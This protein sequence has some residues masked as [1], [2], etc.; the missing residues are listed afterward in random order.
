MDSNDSQFILGKNFDR[1]KILDDT[2]ELL[3]DELNLAVP[4]D[5][6]KKITNEV[7]R[8]QRIKSERFE[9]D[10][11]EYYKISDQELRESN[12]PKDHLE[13]YDF[14]KL[15]VPLTLFAN[16]GYAFTEVRCNI[17]F[18]KG[19]E[20]ERYQPIIYDIFPRQAWQTLLNIE[21]DLQIGLDANLKFKAAEMKSKINFIIKPIKWAIYRPKVEADWGNRECDWRLEG[22]RCIKNEKLKLFIMMKIAKE[23]NTPL[24]ASGHAIA[25]HD[26]QRL[27]AKVI[28]EIIPNFKDA[29]NFFKAGAPLETPPKEWKDILKRP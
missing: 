18:D 28:E 19:N 26:I 12:L 3:E 8:I 13:Y 24:N 21:C 16:A 10:Y 6:N 7:E 15:E 17:Q 22:K 20:N 2:I 14:Y 29:I 11:I 23:R 25:K 4:D 9:F 5:K 1:N 27:S